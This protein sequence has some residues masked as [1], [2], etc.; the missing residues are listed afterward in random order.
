LPSCSS[1]SMLSS[2]KNKSFASLFNFF[3]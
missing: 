3:F 2:L 1:S